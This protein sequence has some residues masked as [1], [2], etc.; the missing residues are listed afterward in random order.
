MDSYNRGY[1]AGLEVEG[2]QVGSA[3]LSGP[4]DGNPGEPLLGDW[5]SAGF[6][7]AAY[8]ITGEGA[9]LV[10]VPHHVIPAKAGT[11]RSAGALA[12]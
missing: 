5:Q 10:Q 12:A 11:H 1:G 7:A 3:V 8:E 6:Y 2:T 4:F 9:G